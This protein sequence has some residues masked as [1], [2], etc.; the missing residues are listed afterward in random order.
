MMIGGGGGLRRKDPDYYASIL[1]NAVLGQ[2]SLSSRLG[3]QVRDTEGLTYTI[4]SRFFSA[5]LLDGLWG[6]YLSVAPENVDKGLASSMGVLR[7]F[8]GEGIAQKE[9]DVEKSAAAGRYLVGL[10]NNAGIAE[11]LAQAE[12]VGLGVSILDEYPQKI[13]AV[14]LEEANR[15]IRTHMAVDKLTTVVAGSVS[16]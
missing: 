13:R 8:S 7:K 10:S 2:S 14:T 1:A 16:R 3:G 15:A 11:A 4:I 9:L 5:E 6:V 12:A